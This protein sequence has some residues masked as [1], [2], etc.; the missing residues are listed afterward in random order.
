MSIQSSLGALKAFKIGGESNPETYYFLNYIPFN[1]NA[2]VNLNYFNSRNNEVY[3]AGQVG[4]TNSNVGSG[5]ASF[6]ELTESLGNIPNITYRSRYSENFNFVSSDFDNTSN[7]LYLLGYRIN[8]NDRGSLV[9]SLNANNSIQNEFYCPGL[10]NITGNPLYREPVN[11]FVLAN[12]SYTIPGIL[13]INSANNRN[14][15]T[16]RG[17]LMNCTGN[18]ININKQLDPVGNA[19]M[20]TRINSCVIDSSENYIASIEYR[21]VPGS[22][23]PAI[24][25]LICNVSSNLTTI[26]WQ[27]YLTYSSN[28]VSPNSGFTVFNGE[29]DNIYVISRSF[30]GANTDLSAITKINNYGNVVFWHKESNIRSNNSLLFSSLIEENGNVYVCTRSI[31][32]GNTLNSQPAVLSIDA[33]TGNIN[34]QRRISMSGDG[35]YSNPGN[36]SLLNYTFENIGL[37]DDGYY[38]SGRILF[39]LNSPYYD[40]SFMFKL[41]KS[42]DLIGNYLVSSSNLGNLYM[43]YSSSNVILSNNTMSLS[44]VGN[45]TITNSTSFPIIDPNITQNSNVSYSNT[46]NRLPW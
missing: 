3:M 24:T 33:N 22:A 42:G 34:W 12:G 39:G 19:L 44:N 6:V 43:N 17:Y 9:V 36:T 38:V 5:P 18:V 1:T 11:M 21:S 26:N 13:D 8:A 30:D 4:P 32:S 40:T 25:G 28:G 2:E 46:I 7:T 29:S 16:T 37:K 35:Q 10:A 15:V 41:P 31:S 23:G 20:S 27:K 45:L 14:N